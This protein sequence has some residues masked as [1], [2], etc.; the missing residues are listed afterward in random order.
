MKVLAV[1]KVLAAWA[2]W[3]E[4]AASAASAAG[5]RMAAGAAMPLRAP[6][7]RTARVT[8]VETLAEDR[9]ARATRAATPE[10]WAGPLAALSVALWAA[11]VSAWAEASVLEAASAEPSEVALGSEA[12]S[13]QVLAA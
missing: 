9:R 11:E 8:K 1:V 2:A 10:A 6:G 13:V 4:R 3:E 7:V 12:A 5:T